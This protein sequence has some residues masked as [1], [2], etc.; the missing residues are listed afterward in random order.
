[1][2][3]MLSSVSPKGQV[4]LP[5]EIRR[6]LGIKPKDKVAFRLEQ[7]KVEIT[8]A[9]SPLADSYQAIP[10]LKP[11]RSWKEIEALVS[12]EIAQDAAREGLT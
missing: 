10:A 7:G 2:K 11:P 4:T 8:P 3:E 5:V 1:M 12:E 9:P 6:S